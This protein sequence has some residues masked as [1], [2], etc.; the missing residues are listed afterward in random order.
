M[1][2][3]YLFGLHL[4]IW[5]CVFFYFFYFILNFV[6][7]LNMH[8]SV[9]KNYL[10]F[11]RGL[12]IVYSYDECFE[13]FGFS[14]NIYLFTFFRS[15]ALLRRLFLIS[16]SFSSSF[17]SVTKLKFSWL[18]EVISATVSLICCKISYKTKPV[19]NNWLK[20]LK[21]TF[22][23]IFPP[24]FRVFLRIFSFTLLF[25]FYFVTSEHS[26]FSLSVIYRY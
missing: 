17:G 26:K 10:W 5:F 1:K 24:F 4:Y 20:H 13:L 6:C 8:V 9:Q 19:I 7:T 25:R 12:N 11:F 18:F 2:S 3:I 23:P 22:S 14:R 15:F 21:A 16:S